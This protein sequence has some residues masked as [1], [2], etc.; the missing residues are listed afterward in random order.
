MFKQE[1]KDYFHGKLNLKGS[2]S[3]MRAIGYSFHCDEF[4]L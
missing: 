3:F 1:G 4:F 2:F